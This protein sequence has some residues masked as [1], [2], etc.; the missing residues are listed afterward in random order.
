MC[1]STA[2]A[3]LAPRSAPAAAAKSVSGG[4]RRRPARGRRSGCV[5][6]RL[7]SVASDFAVDRRRPWA[8]SVDDPYVG[9]TVDFDAVVGQLAMNQGPELG[10][11]GGKH[12]GQLFDLGHRQTHGHG[13]LGHLE[14]DIARADDHGADRAGPPRGSA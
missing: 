13:G 14:A 1:G 12:F 3:P 2:M 4:R 9:G 6:A 5:V 11:D 10:V 8:R 7:H